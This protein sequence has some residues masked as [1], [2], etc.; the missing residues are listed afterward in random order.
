[1]R[2]STNSFPNK[3][4]T[5]LNDLNVQRNDLQRQVSTGQRLEKS[6]DDPSG[7]ARVR[8]MQAEQK[9]AIT[10]RRN[11]ERAESLRSFSEQ[12]MTLLQDL[13][14]LSLDAVGL[15]TGADSQQELD[16]T[17][18][19]IDDILEQALSVANGEAN[20]QYL[21][22]ADASATEP[23]VVTRDAEGR[24]DSVTY[25]GGAGEHSFYIGQSVELSPLTTG[26]QNEEI[27]TWMNELIGLRTALESGD[28][29]QISAMSNALDTS[30]ENLLVSLSDLG[31]K[32]V[33]MNFVRSTENN[34]FNALEDQISGAADVDLTEAIL[35]MNLTQNAYEA[36][37]KSAQQILGMSLLDFV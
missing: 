19:Q 7:V 20:N 18:S 8:V 13:S 22:A 17:A 27:A 12:N 16:K 14:R 31:S 36:A 21:F 30:D 29:A 6:S 28:K 33:R 25:A 9:E 24:V 4:L 1:M 2:V 11:F 35:Q 15:L 34:R 5:Q 32:A 10:L 37:L 26:T 3:L 23:F